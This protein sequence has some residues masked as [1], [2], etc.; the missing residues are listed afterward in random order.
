MK[1]FLFCFILISQFI[2]SQSSVK[3]FSN[4][5]DINTLQKDTV[6]IR[7]K[8]QY[9]NYF[10]INRH[11]YWDSIIPTAQKF[12]R[13]D[14]LSDI[15][16]LKSIISSDV[17]LDLHK[18]KNQVEL[19]IKFAK[20]NRD[21]GFIAT[22][23]FDCGDLFEQKQ[24]T[25]DAIKH[26]KSA[27]ELFALLNKA[28]SIADCNNRLGLLYSNQGN[29]FEA[30]NHFNIS[31]KLNTKINNLKNVSFD[32][33]SLGSIYR[34][35]GD[36]ENALSYFNKA[37]SAS[38]KVDEKLNMASA[39]NFIGVIYLD[40]Y[41]LVEAKLWLNKS[42]ALYEVLNNKSGISVVLNNIGLFLEKQ[43]E[44]TEALGYYQKSLAIAREI[45]SQEG[46]AYLQYHI[47]KIH[48]LTQNHKLA[49]TYL[50]SALKLSQEIGYPKNIYLTAY[51][52][53][54]VD[55]ATNNFSSA[56]K[57]YKLY[58]L[59]KDSISNENTRK[60]SVRNV[61]Q[62]EFEIKATADSVK[63]AE[64]KKV[65]ALKLKQEE[66]K[67]YF[68]FIGLILVLVFGIIMYNRFK[69]TQN[70]KGEIEN[71][72]ALVEAQKELIEGKQKEILDSIKYAKRIQKALLPTE[73][74]LRKYINK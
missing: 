27:L 15:Y 55:S 42:L 30:I 60:A 19:S 61:I 48:F 26:Y 53:S 69:V 71:Q 12:K 66:T 3:T 35:Q 16:F 41:K 68:S 47:G 28:Q 6:W 14:Y 33:I 57:N 56:Y 59:F 50:D 65:S 20:M 34:D 58:H 45:S 37:Y 18:F 49:R 25:S 32:L 5:S 24:L 7:N 2:R 63:V 67:K 29:I 64:E 51:T 38:Q 17:D 62:R 4:I 73:H 23:Y 21:S 36:K 10:R 39:S 46:I 74:F 54:Q 52:L 70:Q 44:L 31:L 40:Q 11:A 8:I 22:C 43:T 13:F 1:K 9:G 72:K